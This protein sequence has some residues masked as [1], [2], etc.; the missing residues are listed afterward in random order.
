MINQGTKKYCPFCKEIVM[1]H[2]LGECGQVEISGVLAKR[3]KIIHPVEL[4][5]C[6]S[7]WY[8]NEIEEDTLNKSS[9]PSK[10]KE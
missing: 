7:S 9:Q 2:V 6:G 3:R 4:S 8:T 10:T 5:G 1:T